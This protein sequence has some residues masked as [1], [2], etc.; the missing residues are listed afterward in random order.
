MIT[1][2]CK[3]CSA[4]V[5][6]RLVETSTPADLGAGR[7]TYL[8]GEAQGSGCAHCGSREYP[9]LVIDDTD[10]LTQPYVPHVPS[11]PRRLDGWSE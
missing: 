11:T 3:S 10:I 1:H 2:V 9:K 5:E 4:P 7:R 6:V 8:W